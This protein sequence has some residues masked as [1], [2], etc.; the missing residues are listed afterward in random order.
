MAQRVK[1]WK[2]LIRFGAIIFMTQQIVCCI[3]LKTLKHRPLD[4]ASCDT[5][6]LSIYLYNK[7]KTYF[8]CLSVR[9]PVRLSVIILYLRVKELVTKRLQLDFQYLNR[10]YFLNSSFVNDFETAKPLRV[11]SSNIIKKKHLFRLSVCLSVS[12]HFVHTGKS[13]GQKTAASRFSIQ[14]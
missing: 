10:I 14:I 5:L 1:W 11:D 6:N 4:R 3:F 13:S 2:M 7:E 8:L 9:P 12:H